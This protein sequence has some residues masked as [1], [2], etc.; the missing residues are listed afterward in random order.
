[1]RVIRLPYAGF[2]PPDFNNTDPASK[3]LIDFTMHTAA[4]MQV[5]CFSFS[6]SVILSQFLHTRLDKIYL[7]EK[8]VQKYS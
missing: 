5:R 1:M 8:F 6:I 3:S 4:C 2:A 7:I